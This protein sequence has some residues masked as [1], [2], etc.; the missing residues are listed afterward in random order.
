MMIDFGTDVFFF[1]FPQIFNWNGSFGASVPVFVAH[2]GVE[3]SEQVVTVI[4]A[5]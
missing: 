2:C 1:G 5:S 3:I 4:L